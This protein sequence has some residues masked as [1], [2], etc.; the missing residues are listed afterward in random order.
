VANVLEKEDIDLFYKLY[1]RLL[2][3]V[4]KQAK[5]LE[6]KLLSPNE[7]VT[8]SLEE[9][10]KIR[11]ALYSQ[12]EYIDQFIENENAQE[13]NNGKGQRILFLETVEKNWAREKMVWNY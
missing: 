9:R 13:L 8:L 6:S 4:N 3:F 10:V 5:I 11:D 12:K 1:S 7:F 2:C